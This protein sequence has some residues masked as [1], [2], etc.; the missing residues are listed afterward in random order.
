MSETKLVIT[1][2]E[3]MMRNKD[4]QAH[5]V[6]LNI[7]EMVQK[8]FEPFP[9]SEAQWEYAIMMVEDAI[10]PLEALRPSEGVLQISGSGLAILAE[11]GVLYRDVVEQVFQQVSRYGSIVNLNINALGYAR[12]LLV[13]EW[14][15]HMDYGMAQLV[16]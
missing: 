3:V 5:K 8:Y 4:G 15:H 6:N 9:P 13:R 16:D 14:L 12:L 2:N 1:D 7:I 10:A 11:S